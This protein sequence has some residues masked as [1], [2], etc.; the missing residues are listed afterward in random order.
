MY[1][2]FL[3]EYCKFRQYKTI[4]EVGVHKAYTTVELCEAAC[5]NGGKVYGYDF[6]GPVNA[7]YGTGF[8]N[9]IET[10]INN[11]NNRGYTEEHY[12]LIKVNTRLPEFEE[13]LKKD[14]GGKIDFAFI[15][16]D[17]SYEG[18]KNDFLK[19]YPFLNEKGSI[20]F[21]DTYSHTGCRKFMLDLYGEL[22][23]GTFDLVNFEKGES[24]ADWGLSLL[25]KR[26]FPLKREG[27]T[28]EC[29]DPNIKPNEVYDQEEKWYKSQIK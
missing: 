4:V 1:R 9:D 8:P 24:G 17:H 3:K 26:F 11:L 12:K 15:D 13:S 2:I 22:N 28:W 21:H 19:V 23:D 20:A 10:A 14:I 27:I 16:A 5:A 6:F 7:I 25:V 18:V 29:H